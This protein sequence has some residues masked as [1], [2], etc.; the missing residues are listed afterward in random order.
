MSRLGLLQSSKENIFVQTIFWNIVFSAIQNGLRFLL[1]RQPSI[2]F[3]LQ[4]QKYVHDVFNSNNH[5]S[6]KG[7][8][9][10]SVAMSLAT[11]KE[12][13]NGETITPS[14]LFF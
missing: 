1:G 13:I 11:Y 5:F 4:V 12:K 7:C 10:T 9:M 2:L 3:V 6:L 8:A 14:T